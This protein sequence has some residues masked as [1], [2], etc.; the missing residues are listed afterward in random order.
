MFGSI[1]KNNQYNLPNQH[2]KKEN[3]MIF[4]IDAGRKPFAFMII[5]VKTLSH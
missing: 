2:T 3:C 5:H 1:F 4:S